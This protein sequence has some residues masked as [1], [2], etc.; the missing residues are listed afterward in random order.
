MTLLS[1][2]SIQR[3]SSSMSQSSG[4]GMYRY[5]GQDCITVDNENY[6]IGL[7]YDAV[8]LKITDGGELS[9][10]QGCITA[11]DNVTV[12][13]DTDGVI[14]ISAAMFQSQFESGDKAKYDRA[15][16]DVSNIK[17]DLIAL[18]ARVTATET[19]TNGEGGHTAQISS[20]D[21]R[22]TAAEGSLNSHNTRIW[23]L[24]QAKLANDVNI[25]NLQT[26]TGSGTNG[27]STQISGLRTDLTALGQTV[28]EHTTLL[29]ELSGTNAGLGSLGSRIDAANLRIDGCEAVSTGLNTRLSDVEDS[30]D[31]EDTGILARLDAHDSDLTDCSDNI[32]NLDS[33]LTALVP[34][35]VTLENANQNALNYDQQISDLS[36]AVT[37]ALSEFTTVSGN[38]DTLTTDLST[39]D[40]TVNV[41]MDGRIGTLE[42]FVTDNTEAISGISTLATDLGTVS[43]GLSALEGVVQALDDSTS[44]ADTALDTRLTAAEGQIETN[45]NNISTV[46]GNLSTLSGTVTAM[47]DTIETIQGDIDAL[48]GEMITDAD[49]EVTVVDAPELTYTRLTSADD[50]DLDRLY[51]I[52]DAVSYNPY[53]PE[54][55]QVEEGDTYDSS[56]PYFLWSD[57]IPVPVEPGEEPKYTS[58]YVAYS[59]VDQAGFEDAILEG[60]YY[61]ATGQNI[62][63]YDANNGYEPVVS[64]YLDLTETY[65]TYAPDSY[66]SIFAPDM[67]KVDTSASYDNNLVYFIKNLDGSYFKYTYDSATFAA[68]LAVG[69]Y[70]VDNISAAITAGIYSVATSDESPNSLELLTSG[71]GVFTASSG[72]GN[73]IEVS[74]NGT[75]VAEATAA[76]KA[77]VSVSVLV[78]AS[79]TVTV[80]VTP[81][82]KGSGIRGIASIRYF[83]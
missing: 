18:T 27:H 77:E 56:I 73:K 50:I 21:S 66:S 71:F 54:A 61:A 24:E 81:A 51:Y 52:K 68:D 47:G 58:G 75:K 44:A 53:Y 72:T 23:N 42:D 57:D 63:T 34:R 67:V 74:V 41:T 20:L 9:L 7:N 70:V 80:S 82:H 12:T 78:P 26:L 48:Q 46:T 59:H 33:I 55:T 17:I 30:I 13:T 60:L 40:N 36:D 43:S 62:F 32:L 16:T 3:T 76:E 31:H 39:L 65:Y 10:N 22:M 37:N 83:A 49:A 79:A 6:R 35:V 38:V 5:L 69:L 29:S 28:G 15:C 2:M 25:E 1:N 45:S 8:T 11:G 19:L 64:S 4:A 14:T